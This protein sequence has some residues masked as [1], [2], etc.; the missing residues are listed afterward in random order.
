MAVHSIGRDAGAYP[1]AEDMM[2]ANRE[3]GNNSPLST[4]IAQISS[5]PETIGFSAE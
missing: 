1:D 5:I 2:M 4:I 3:H